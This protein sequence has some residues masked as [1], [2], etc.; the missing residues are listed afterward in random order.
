MSTFLLM[1][2]HNIKGMAQNTTWWPCGSTE[3]LLI[4]VE[5]LHQYENYSAYFRKKI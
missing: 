3:P 2:L 4:T 1:D 5:A